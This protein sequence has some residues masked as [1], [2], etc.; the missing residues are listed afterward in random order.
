MI[1]IRGDVAVQPLPDHTYTALLLRGMFVL[2]PQRRGVV[3]SPGRIIVLV[4][5][6]APSHQAG[7]GHGVPAI[8]FVGQSVGDVGLSAWARP[9]DAVATDRELDFEHPKVFP[10][11]FYARADK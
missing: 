4:D 6:I 8:P 1:R 10:L 3:Q 11:I 5:V 7:R 2:G 9:C